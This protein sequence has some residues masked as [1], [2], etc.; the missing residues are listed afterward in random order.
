MQLGLAGMPEAVATAKA[1]YHPHGIVFDGSY[2]YVTTDAVGG[3]LSRVRESDGHVDQLAVT[4]GDGGVA[5]DD[6]CI[7]YSTLTGI[8]TLAKDAPAMPPP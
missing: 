8:F 1:L 4:L 3:V 7:Y 2:F 6:Q 5:V